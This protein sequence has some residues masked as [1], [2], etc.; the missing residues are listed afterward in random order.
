MTL[1]QPGGSEGTR[2]SAPFAL[3]YKVCNV[4]WSI[5]VRKN[6]SHTYFVCSSFL[7]PASAGSLPNWPGK[8]CVHACK[9]RAAEDDGEF[10]VEHQRTGCHNLHLRL[11]GVGCVYIVAAGNKEALYVCICAAACCSEQLAKLFSCKIHRGWREK[12][13]GLPSQRRACAHLE[14][15]I[16]QD[17]QERPK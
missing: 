14:G 13:L 16:K 5:L 10:T 2:S 15:E 3:P 8:G 12:N 6:P 11:C 1:R 17:G 7:F 4:I 9:R